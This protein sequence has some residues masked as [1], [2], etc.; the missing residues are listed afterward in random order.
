MFMKTALLTAGVIATMGMGGGGD[1]APAAGTGKMGTGSAAQPPKV[2]HGKTTA[3]SVAILQ[4]ALIDV[5]ILGH[6]FEQSITDLEELKASVTGAE[7]DRKK[8]KRKTQGVFYT[9][10]FVLFGDAL[11]HGKGNVAM[12]AVGLLVAA[13]A[14]AS[15][16]FLT[17]FARRTRALMARRE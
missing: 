12:I 15:T 13:A 11:L 17:V 3:A 14:F 6:I 7:F 16:T 1:D 8:G 9:P 4:G 10:A 2:R 5:D